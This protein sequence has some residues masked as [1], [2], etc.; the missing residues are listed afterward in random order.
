MSDR[1]RL[2]RKQFE[3]HSYCR[4]RLNTRRA[5]RVRRSR[6]LRTNCRREPMRQVGQSPEKPRRITI[7]TWVDSLTDCVSRECDA[8]R[9][10]I[11]GPSSKKWRKCNETKLARCPS[12]PGFAGVGRRGSCCQFSAGQLLG[13]QDISSYAK[14]PGES[15]SVVPGISGRRPLS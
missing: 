5:S 15:P 12:W 11:D 4:S 13:P 2:G 1:R 6:S 7:A 8:N 9:G 14:P 10:R 3:R